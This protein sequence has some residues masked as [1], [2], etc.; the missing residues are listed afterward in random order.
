M[1]DVLQGRRRLLPIDDLVVT[2]PTG[3]GGAVNNLVLPT[4]NSSIG[5]PA[6]YPITTT[7]VPSFATAAGRM[8]NSPRDVVFTMTAGAV[9]VRDQNPAGTGHRLIRGVGQPGGLALADFNNDGFADVALLTA[10]APGSSTGLLRMVSANDPNHL[11]D[12]LFVSTGVSP[13]SIDFSR[14]ISIAAA[15]S[16]ATAP[17]RW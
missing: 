2:S 17:A 1:T 8:L 4:S 16:A 6:S 15:A 9:V 11:S 14:P 13:P 5:T 12:G 3:T 7:S 10:S